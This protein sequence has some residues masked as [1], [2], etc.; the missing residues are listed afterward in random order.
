MNPIRI[1]VFVSVRQ[2]SVYKTMNLART[3]CLAMLV[4][5]SS[6]T[7]A[8]ALQPMSLDDLVDTADTIIVGRSMERS[9]R[10]V[11]GKIVT[12]TLFEIDENIKGEGTNQYTV[13][14]MGGT[15]MHETLKVPVTMSVSG[16]ILFLPNE[17]I[18]LFTKKN[19]MGHHQVVGL[20][21]GKFRIRRDKSSG[22]RTIPVGMKK[23]HVLGEKLKTLK[24]SQS[25]A[26]RSATENA[27]NENATNIENRDIELE[28]FL[29]LIRQRVTKSRN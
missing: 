21:Q 4:C 27:T 29:N 11:D 17:E 28:E 8:A 2:R 12:D 14:T 26:S 10:W 13:T 6:L 9:S 18:V 23:I 5:V 3:V 15:A 25:R 24:S 22:K 16:G 7:M 1:K 20:T 19:K